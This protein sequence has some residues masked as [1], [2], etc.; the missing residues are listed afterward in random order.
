M[1]SIQID[2]QT[3]LMSPF[4][5]EDLEKLQNYFDTLSEKSKKR[6]GP[7]PFNHEAIIET[8]NNSSN[9]K[10]F[11]AQ[12]EN[13]KAIVAYTV[14]KFGWVDFDKNR[15]LSY[16]LTVN[17]YDTT[18]AP[19][20]ADQW[21]GKGLGSK[22]FEYVVNCLKNDFKATRVILWGGVQSDNE[23]AVRLYKRFNFRQIGRFEHNGPNM[24]MILDLS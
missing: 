7:H 19:S 6:Y 4:K 2:E 15:L 21:Q 13:D 1:K 20:V 17:Q 22:F 24:D 8:Y 9:Y 16:G 11:V 23:K 10:M 12:K 14:V 5:I 3:I 18:I